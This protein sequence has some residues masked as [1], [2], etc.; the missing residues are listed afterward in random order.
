[1]SV[2]ELLRQK[3]GYLGRGHP[4]G[5]G[6]WRLVVEALLPG[7]ATS[8]WDVAKWDIDVWSDLV[9]TDLTPWFRGCQ[10]SRGA[11]Q[12]FGRPRVGELTVTLANGDRRWSP[13]N[14]SPPIGS[15]AYFA[16]GT[17]IRVGLVSDSDPRADG[18]LPQITAVVDDWPEESVGGDAD[19]WTTVT[20]YE[21]ISEL[22]GIDDN[23]LP[24]VVGNGETCAARITR[25]LNAADW[26]YGLDV[27]HGNAAFALQSTDMANNRLAEC[28][29]AADSTNN[30][31]RAGRDGRAML[32]EDL[33]DTY[34]WPLG[35]FSTYAGTIPRLG[36][37]PTLTYGPDGDD[38]ETTLFAPYDADS[39]TVANNADHVRNDIR[40]ARIGGTQQI[41]EHQAS[42][43]RYRR[44]TLSR[45]DL[46]TTTNG[47][48]A[49]LA[50]FA[51]NKLARHTLRVAALTVATSDRGDDVYLAVAAADIGNQATFLPPGSE[52]GTAVTHGGANTT[53]FVNAAI[54]SMT[55]RVTVRS[56]QSVT[57]STEFGFATRDIFNLPAAILPQE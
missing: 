8:L 34:P 32:H 25:L 30:V 33:F 41:S 51:R 42:I 27:G 21:T 3:P 29:N 7:H 20:A 28:Y 35:A 11:D 52:P 45:N 18:W 19:S 40:F 1:M 54:E 31:F 44:R 4:I 17:V 53:P 43:A 5:V 6:D 55:H 9:W 13:W 15:S 37:G 22:A 12:P 48:V 24:G 2:A 46:R 36:F 26:R 56:S 47:D 49:L 16:P 23:A 57:W 39:T 38:F 14:P 10:W 50:Q